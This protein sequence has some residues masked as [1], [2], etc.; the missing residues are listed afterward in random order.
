MSTARSRLLVVAQPVF[1]RTNQNTLRQSLNISRPFQ[2]FR[3]GFA[4]L[5]MTRS[6]LLVCDGFLGILCALYYPQAVD[7][8]H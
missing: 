7:T 2:T 1:L 8:E 6:E 3:S 4:E 5:E